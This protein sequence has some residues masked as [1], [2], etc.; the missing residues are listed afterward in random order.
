MSEAKK[1]ILIVDD[2]R[3]V[4]QLLKLILLK[5]LKCQITEAQDGLEAMEIL[6][7]A[8]FD[9]VITDI[10][11]PNMNGLSLVSKVRSELELKV[12]IIIITTMGKEEDRDKGLVLGADSS[13]TKPF[14][15]PN[16]V[17]AASDLL[18]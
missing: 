14:N 1:N 9:L 4:R 17:K 7:D 5:G 18:R 12:P 15:G 3:T 2:S 10:N 11:M 6:Q 13:L 8:P 16:V